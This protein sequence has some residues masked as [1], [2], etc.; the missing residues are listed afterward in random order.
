MDLIQEFKFS[1]KQVN[2]FK[3]ILDKKSTSDKDSPPMFGDIN[4]KEWFRL[5]ALHIWQHDKQNSK[6]FFDLFKIMKTF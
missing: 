3:E 5:I 1:I 6:I 4:T 2:E